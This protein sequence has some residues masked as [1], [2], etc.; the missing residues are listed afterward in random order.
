M[1]D[2]LRDEGGGMRDEGRNERVSVEAAQGAG[3]TLAPSRHLLDSESHSSLI[4]PP[5][6]LCLWLDWGLVV[7]LFVLAVAAPHSIAATQVAWLCGMF[8]WV[9]RYFVRPRPVLHRTPLDYALLGFFILTFLSALVSYDRGESIGKLRSASLF[10]IFYL[11]VENVPSRRVLRALVLTLVASCMVNV[12]YTFAERMVGRGV[13]IAGLSVES[14]LYAAGIRDGD[15]LLAV[16]G[17]A[18]R[19]PEAL[20]QAL[21]QRPGRAPYQTIE[22]M[23]V[24]GAARD[25]KAR[26]NFYRVE[27]RPTFEVERGRLLPGETPLARLGIGNWSRGRDERAAG[28]Y[29]HYVTYAEVLQLVG[30]LALGLLIAQRRKWDLP[31]VLL[32]ATVGGITAALLLTVTR[33]AWLGLLLSAFTIVLI[34]AS[35][36]TWLVVAALA[37]PLA[38]AGLFVLQ[39]KRQVGFLDKRDGST[40]WRLM[41]YR[42]SLGLLVSEP[43][44]MLV[45]VGMDSIKTH[46]REWGLFDKG[47]QSI[48]HLHSTPLQIAVERGLPALLVWL[49]LVATYARVLWRLARGDGR[50]EDWVERGLVL[51]A[52]GGLVG[53]VASGMV[54]YNLGDS[55]VSMIFYFVM[56]LAL[57]IERSTRLES[58]QTKFQQS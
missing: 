23:P 55:E 44:H 35:R 10:T 58:Q 42:E 5:S 6:S 33:A 25:A 36:R 32:A 47:R 9:I 8:L 24:A 45:G 3:D 15:T 51:G 19:S 4:P 26:V 34:G 38:L 54:H 41:V 39:Q 16:D 40:A 18:L 31:K 43:R 48:G 13:K 7:C 21:E 57:V 49:A 53:F 28:F 14:P 50:V 12:V 37:L 22:Q 46:Y 11:V 1:K 20:E 30:S 52:L 27:G 29:G 2:F 56:G 17:A